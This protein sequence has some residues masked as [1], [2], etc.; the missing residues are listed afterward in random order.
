MLTDPHSK[1]ET[2]YEWLYGKDFE[3]KSDK[4]RM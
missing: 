2:N 1:G 3:G 4:K